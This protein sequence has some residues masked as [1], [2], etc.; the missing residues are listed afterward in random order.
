MISNLSSSVLFKNHFFNDFCLSFFFNASFAIYFFFSVFVSFTSIVFCFPLKD[1]RSIN[2]YLIDK[3]MNLSLRKKC[4]YSEFFWSV[5]S[6][7]RGN[8]LGKIRT[9]K[10]PKTDAFDAVRSLCMSLKR[11]HFCFHFTPW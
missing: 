7:I 5:F 1:F 4:S 2:H 9:R 6:L 10:I 11:T 8:F 3:S